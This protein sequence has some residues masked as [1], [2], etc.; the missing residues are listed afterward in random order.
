MTWPTCGASTP[1]RKPTLPSLT[2]PA[3]M[4]TASSRNSPNGIVVMENYYESNYYF[5]SRPLNSLSDFEGLK[6]RSH[7]TVLSD[8]LGGMGADPQFMAFAD[9]YT[10]LERGRAGRGG[11]LWNLR[12]RRALVR[13][14]GLP[15]RPNRSY[16]RHLD[17][18]E[19][20]RV[21]SPSRRIC[22]PSSR[23]KASATSALP[24]NG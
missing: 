20:G 7:S 1:T 4:S 21:G 15:G 24:A 13:G 16:R 10:A 2:L 19:Q 12:F 6:T 18:H 14:D 17:Y 11:V 5:S 22:R 23:R 3:R 9:V 8:L